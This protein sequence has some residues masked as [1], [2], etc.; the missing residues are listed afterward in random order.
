VRRAIDEKHDALQSGLAERYT[1]IQEEKHYEIH[2]IN[3]SLEGKEAYR[4]CLNVQITRIFQLRNPN[5]HIV[6]LLPFPIDEET[7]N[8]YYK[9]MELEEIP[10]YKERVSFIEVDPQVNFTSRLNV[11]TKLYYNS[12]AIRKLKKKIKD[13]AAYFVISYP[14]LVDIKLSAYL[15]IPILG[16]NLI[17]LLD[18]QKRTSLDQFKFDTL[19]KHVIDHNNGP[20]NLTALSDDLIAYC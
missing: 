17:K 18:L 12:K 4:E 11:S 16:G 10:N 20:H 5:K 3:E 14:S 15:N 7:I 1:K 19:E 9:I 6:Y 13:F 2:V 8:Y